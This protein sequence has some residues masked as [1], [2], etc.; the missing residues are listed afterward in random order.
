MDTAYEV[1]KD[2]TKSTYNGFIKFLTKRNV[3]QMVMAFVI[4]GY[5]SDMSKQF[6]SIIIDPITDK[7]LSSDKKIEDYTL[8]IFGMNMRIGRLIYLI[9]RFLI[10]VFILYLLF[11]II[12]K[13][14][15]GVDLIDNTEKK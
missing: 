8:N 11:V 2:T 1:I 14:I 13:K 5:V 12:P 7:L 9:T 10:M 15:L 4:A 6:T 3:I